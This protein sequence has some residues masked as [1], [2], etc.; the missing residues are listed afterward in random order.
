MATYQSISDAV[1]ETYPS[2]SI[3]Y[4]G[5]CSGSYTQAGG[6]AGNVPKPVTVTYTPI[7]V[8]STIYNPTKGSKR[9]WEAIKKSGKI[10]MTPYSRS[11]RTVEQFV[12]ERPYRFRTWPWAA[13]WCGT[14]CSR[15]VE[16]GPK[17]RYWTQRDHIG[18]L[19]SLN[20]EDDTGPTRTN[21]ADQVAD[22]IATTQ[23]EAYANAL[24]TYDLLT[25]LAEGK[26]TLSYLLGKVSGASTV[27]QKFA[28]TDE[29]TYRRARGL[30]SKQMLTSS[31]KALRRLGSRWMEYRYAIMPLIYSMKD[32]NEMLAKRDAVFKTERSRQK[33]HHDF[34]R[35]EALPAPW[36]V[37]TY[38]RCDLETI[39]SSTVKLG[40]DRGALQ[41][42]L[43]QTAFNPFKTA[44]EL[45][46]YSF[47][48]D[49][50]LNVGDLI[51]SQTS[52]NLASQTVCCTS[53]RKRETTEIWLFDKSSDVS[54]ANRSANPCGGAQSFNYVHTRNVEQVLQR[55]TVESYNRFLWS[56]PQPKLV[57]D[58]YLSWKRII[59]GLVLSYQPTK[60]LLRSL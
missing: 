8:T 50:F 42:V 22:A 21:H 35:D 4:G 29:E 55:T 60:K 41:R 24:S 58:P 38:T 43:S 48:V 46:P 6:N 16:L 7:V 11:G 25:E 28:S 3:P 18:S 56:K 59:D 14:V 2:V 51:T 45:I 12:V 13:A 23:Q 32:V 10:S 17:D 37:F 31:D 26:E 30:T 33:I 47:V 39:V 1:S 5:A 20:N 15:K 9:N 19:S 27:L 34:T 53:V 52:I 57:F 44:W 49:W 36:G 40:Y 54:T